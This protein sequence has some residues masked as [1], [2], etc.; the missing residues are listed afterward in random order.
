MTVYF[1]AFA[2]QYGRH[3]LGGAAVLLMIQNAAQ[4]AFP[5]KPAPAPAAIQPIFGSVGEDAA[6]ALLPELQRFNDQFAAL[7]AMGDSKE[8]VVRLE[9]RE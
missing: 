5:P 3:W 6:K 1:V 4:W 9:D 7:V 8:I 2:R